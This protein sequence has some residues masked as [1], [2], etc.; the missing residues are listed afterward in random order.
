[1]GKLAPLSLLKKGIREL[2][3]C[4]VYLQPTNFKITQR[5]DDVGGLKKLSKGLNVY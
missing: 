3:F 4:Y 1:V 2:G 5:V